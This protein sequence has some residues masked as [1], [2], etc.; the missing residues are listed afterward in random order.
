MDTDL[1]NIL[2]KLM[3]AWELLTNCR[4]NAHIFSKQQQQ[5]VHE[6]HSVSSVSCQRAV[7]LTLMT[8]CDTG[9]ISRTYQC[10]L[11]RALIASARAAALTGNGHAC[12]C[13]TGASDVQTCKD[14]GMRN[15]QGL[16]KSAD[17]RTSTRITK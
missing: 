4:M 5:S 9:S 12:R 6:T 14:H 11:C 10:T 3:F 17:V 8:S 16:C 15:K 7:P 2:D 1:S 13:S